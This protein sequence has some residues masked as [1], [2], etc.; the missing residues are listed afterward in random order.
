MIWQTTNAA[1][2]RWA[3]NVDTTAVLWILTGSQAR[4]IESSGT[5]NLYEPSVCSGCWSPSN[6][7]Q[8]NW[9][10]WQWSVQRR[11]ARQSTL[12]PV[13]Y[14]LR[15]SCTSQPNTFTHWKQRSAGNFILFEFTF[16]SNLHMKYR[17]IGLMLCYMKFVFSDG[18][19]WSSSV[20]ATRP[21][22]SSKN[23]SDVGPELGGKDIAFDLQ[24][25]SPYYMKNYQSI[26]W[27][28]FAKFLSGFGKS[29]C[30]KYSC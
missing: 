7:V 15:Y 23:L 17:R 11:I 12:V 1:Q 8:P 18:E 3:M 6:Y 2:Q 22:C 30:V 14:Y 24:W 13:S 10:G 26:L 28:P 25:G 4:F 16:W 5:L 9:R 19:H 27:A 29:V 20:I 21:E